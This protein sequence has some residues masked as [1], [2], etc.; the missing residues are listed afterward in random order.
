M[1][2]ALVYQTGLQQQTRE[3][4]EPQVIREIEA[5]LK[6]LKEPAAS[7]VFLMNARLSIARPWSDESSFGG[8]GRS[9]R[10]EVMRI[11]YRPAPISVKY[12][13]LQ[14]GFIAPLCV[15][16]LEEL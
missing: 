14:S 8:S 3:E 5:E 15:T 12:F 11:F 1:I 16:P 10:T 2:K 4:N 13:A 9:G 7:M 6:G